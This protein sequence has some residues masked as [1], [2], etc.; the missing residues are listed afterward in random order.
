MDIIWDLET[1]KHVF[2]FAMIRSDGK[3]ERVFECSKYNNDI[4]KVFAA[5]DYF[6]ENNY[7]MVGFN[8]IGFDYPI[9]HEM[10]NQREKLLNMS[11]SQ[12][13]KFVF[14]LAQ[15]Q[16]ESFKDEGFGNT[17]KSTDEYIKQID[18]YRIWHFNNKAKSTGLKMLEFNMK[19]DNIEDLPFGFEADLTQEQIVKLKA[20][21]QHDVSATLRF[22]NESKSQIEFRDA[23]SEKMGRDVT[24]AD[25]TKIGSEY[26][27]MRLE[28]AGVQLYSYVDGKRKMK[29]TKRPKIDLNDCVFDYYVFNRPEFAAIEQWFRKQVITETKGVFSDIEEHLLGEV[30]NYAEME[31]KRIRFKQKPTEQEKNLFVRLHPL[32]WFEEQELKATEYVFNDDGSHVMYQPVDEQGNPKGKPKKQ[33]QFKKSYW[34][35]YRIAT[36]LNVVIDGLR[37]DYGVGGIHASLS[38]KVA[39][40]NSS[41]LI[42]DADV[43]SMYP[44]IAIS[45]KVYPEHLGEEFCVIY[46][47]MYEQRKSHGKGTPENAMLKLAL[48][49]T[50]GKSNDKYSVFYD[51][52]FTM[53]IT[54]NGQLAL[55]ML[56]DMLLT[57]VPS[58]KPIQLNTDGVT[59]AF[60]H[61]DEQLY[62]DVC[63]RWESVVGLELEYADYSKM[64]IR[65]VNNYVAVYTN[66]K[67]KR[68]GAYQFEGLGWHQ[69]QGG[70]IIPKAAN[71]AM[72]EGADIREYIKKH[73]DRYDFLLR[74]K[75]PRSSRLVLVDENGVEKQQQNIC[76]YYISKK[77]GKLVKIMPPLEGDTEER[78]LGIDTDW[79]VST[80][81]N[82]SDFRWDIDYEYYVSEAEKL[83][84]L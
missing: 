57:E 45:N 34:G 59:V 3:L 25:D 35:C 38:D 79:L 48:N 23:L 84:I 11:G 30:A 16:I 44:N 70:L 77:G 73:T 14:R 28:Q 76:R 69:N 36:T 47:D 75:V 27:Q 51:P 8:N 18:L 17:I 64:H 31:I 60:K 52:M 40:A 43:S 74:T 4:T 58:V 2:T 72:L 1:Y 53:K 33:R 12:I 50:Y 63:K 5:V 20:Y 81:N 26:F 37:I 22:Y 78:R 71:A 6:I 39:K 65:D 15:K 24:N 62:V 21:N 61:E 67:V 80:C 55:S 56:L 49:G 10:I 66:G 9:L 7:R 83:V 54:I 46:K 29:Q 19:M 68:K 42:R 82:I 13:A 32:C 41:Y